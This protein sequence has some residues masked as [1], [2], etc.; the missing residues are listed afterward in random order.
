M[1]VFDYS[2]IIGEIVQT[3]VACEATFYKIAGPYA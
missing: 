2:L 1:R 3:M